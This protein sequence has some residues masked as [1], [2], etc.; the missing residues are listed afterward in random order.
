MHSDMVAAA[1]ATLKQQSY[2]LANALDALDAAGVTDV[3][4][5]IAAE[6]SH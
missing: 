2:E 3:F 5:A 4:A 6:V 1:V